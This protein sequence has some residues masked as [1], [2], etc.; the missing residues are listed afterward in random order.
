MNL[1]IDMKKLLAKI[2]KKLQFTPVLLNNTK[3][4]CTQTGTTFEYSSISGMDEY[5]IIAVNFVAYEA[6]Q[7]VYFVR[8]L[9]GDTSL[10]DAPSSGR[11]RG[12]LRVD[13]EN[14]AIGVRC[15]N[16]G[17]AGTQYDLVY[18]KGVYGIA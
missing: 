1:M 14:S 4:E 7:T 3:Y 9:P 8:P 2:I 11:F 10:T 18:F 6:Q 17:T 16:A 13:W 15:I 12:T 5:N